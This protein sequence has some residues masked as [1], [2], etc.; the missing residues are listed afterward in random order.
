MEFVRAGAGGTPTPADLID[1]ML[2]RARAH[3]GGE[4]AADLAEAFVA[5]KL[6]VNAELDLPNGWKVGP[7][8]TG[9][10]GVLSV[11]APY[12]ETFVV[13]EKN[14]PM[15]PVGQNRTYGAGTEKS[16][17]DSPLA[18][19]STDP[20]RDRSSSSS[21]PIPRLQSG[22][23][24]GRGYTQEEVAALSSGQ[25]FDF[26]QR[27]SEQSS[28]PGQKPSGEAFDFKSRAGGESF[29]FKNRSP[30]GSPLAGMS[31][32]LERDRGS[33]SSLPIPKLQTGRPQGRGLTEE[34][35]AAPNSGEPF[36]FTQLSGEQSSRPG[37]KP[38]GEAFD[39]KSRAGGES[40]D[41]KK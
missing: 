14:H 6:E 13:F 36:D 15:A 33:S 8:S 20:E 19:M 27:S 10:P 39:F 1:T 18:G 4:A 35:I 7:V 32:D 23:P 12:G 34:E 29:D 2:D 21:L 16:P 11:S 26:A 9:E 41:F 28:R 30:L 31:T 40:F 22:R 5:G 17:L 25:P 3:P 24:Q 38:S 37:Q